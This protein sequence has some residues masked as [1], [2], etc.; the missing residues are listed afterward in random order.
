MALTDSTIISAENNFFISRKNISALTNALAS[1]HMVTDKST[2]TDR[3][4]QFKYNAYSPVNADAN[5]RLTY[6]G[7]LTANTTGL[8]GSANGYANTFVNTSTDFSTTDFTVL[9][10]IE[11][12]GGGLN[13][14]EFGV[15]DSGAAGLY[16]AA[17]FSDNNTYSS[18]FGN[19]SSSG[20]LT[21]NTQAIYS[22]KRS[23]STVT[24]KRNNVT[25]FTRTEVGSTKVNNPIFLLCR[26][27]NNTGQSF[28]SREYSFFEFI[29]G[30]L[31]AQQE[32]DFYN[33]LI[34]REIAL[35]RPVGPIVSDPDAQAFVN[36][37][38]L[39]SQTQANAINTLVIGMKAQGLWT[40]MEAIYPFVGGTAF[41]HKFNLKNPTDS[42]AAYRLT[43]GGTVT[44]D[45]NGITGNGT[46]GYADT[47]FVPSTG[48][49][50]GNAHIATYDRTTTQGLGN[51]TI[52]SFS[53]GNA[54][55]IA[56]ND[57]QYAYLGG[58]NNVSSDGR[59]N[60]SRLRVA[61]RTANNVFKAFRDGTQVGV[62]VTAVQST[63]P[64]ANIRL[65]AAGGL[66][67]YSN[68]N[69][70]FASVGRGLSDSETVA[71]NT[72]VNTFQTTLGRNV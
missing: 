34:T 16:L 71:Y 55:W 18:A 44:H 13:A 42:N 45:S 48:W 64:T 3:L 65:L 19:S 68:H 69:L 53:T 28:S 20:N 22:F 25:L 72:L 12:S 41:S 30:A 50:V 67:A 36:A 4:N 17:K 10:I 56:Y 63:Y 9:F 26:N 43:F 2:N 8:Q 61:T 23:G 5:K 52:G 32:T 66:T 60:I 39:T 15:V 29:N 70:A 59:I 47:Y 11:T 49:S 40:K 21:T 35:G 31:T 57:S 58:L 33:A 38:E 54:V 62:T 24:L 1:Y 27:F 7:T 6:G 14:I 46:N 51:Y 37:A